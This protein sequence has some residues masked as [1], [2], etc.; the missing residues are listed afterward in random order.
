MEELGKTCF[1]L[2]IDFIAVK[3]Y[4]CKYKAEVSKEK[5]S[6]FYWE[7]SFQLNYFIPSRDNVNKKVSEITII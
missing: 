4:F 7:I 5:S 2:K 1:P 6:I 3:L